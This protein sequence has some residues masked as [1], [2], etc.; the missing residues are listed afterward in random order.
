ML[1]VSDKQAEIIE[2]SRHRAMMTS[3]LELT[4][5]HRKNHIQP[6]PQK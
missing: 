4:P 3:I 5:C 2:V 1:D 6:S